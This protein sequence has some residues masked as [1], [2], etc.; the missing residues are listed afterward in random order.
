MKRCDPLI[1]GTLQRV[2]LQLSN[3]IIVKCYHQRQIKSICRLVI[4]CVAKGEIQKFEYLWG[5]IF[6]DFLK[7]KLGKFGRIGMCQ[8]Y[9]GHGKKR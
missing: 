1:A 9:V 5:K 8:K 2:F 4:T 6:E 3:V 7:G